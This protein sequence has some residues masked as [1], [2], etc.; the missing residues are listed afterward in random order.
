MAMAHPPPTPE[1]AIVKKSKLGYR[2]V[3]ATIETDSCSSFEFASTRDEAIRRGADSLADKFVASYASTP[4]GSTLYPNRADS[5]GED[6]H[7]YKLQQ[8]W[9]AATTAKE[10]SQIL[11]E[12]IKLVED[13]MPDEDANG[14]GWMFACWSEYMDDHPCRPFTIELCDCSEGSTS[15][16]TDE[17]MTVFLQDRAATLKEFIEQVRKA[18]DWL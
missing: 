18:N 17:C 10:R 5:D 12:L 7:Y 3:V 13:A 15:P 11:T 4:T 8:R 16:I 2:F 9:H 14:G 1:P 6:S